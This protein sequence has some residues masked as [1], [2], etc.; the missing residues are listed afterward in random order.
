MTVFENG[1]QFDLCD[2]NENNNLNSIDMTFVR[3]NNW[4][5]AL[6]DDLFTDS[7]LDAPRYENFS[8]PAVNI[9]EKNTN[10][11]MELAVPGLKKEDFNIE[12][13]D[14]VLTVSATVPSDNEE[15]SESKNERFTRR[16]FQYGTFKRTFNLPETINVE[17]IQAG[18]SDGVLTIT[19]PKKEEQKAL[20]KMVEIS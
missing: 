3:D 5:P 16:E 7:R 1:T 14:E 15:T 18:Y 11:V 4:L 10:F 8:I 2:E 6:L 12:V 17:D 13:E 9:R 19:L 20:K